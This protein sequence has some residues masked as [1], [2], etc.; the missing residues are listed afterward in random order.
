MEPEQLEA[1]TERMRKEARNAYACRMTFTDFIPGEHR[2]T[3]LRA[4]T[5]VLNT[6]VALF[7]FA[8]LVDG[9]PTSA[10]CFDRRIPGIWGPH[11]MDH[12]HE[13]LCDGATDKAREM[14][15]DFDPSILKFSPK[16]IFS[17]PFALLPLL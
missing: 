16:V 11:I 4:I 13:E 6:E 1:H 8:E 17:L 14:L 5:N 12:T 2:D 7:T 9:L 15:A 3:L 10:D